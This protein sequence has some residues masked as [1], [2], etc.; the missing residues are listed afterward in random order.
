ME[1]QLHILVAALRCM[2]SAANEGVSADKTVN[3][4][5]LNYHFFQHLDL[6]IF[7]GETWFL[8]QFSNCRAKG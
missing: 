5:L 4:Y 8:L 1:Q 2:F 6:K 3:Q 7:K